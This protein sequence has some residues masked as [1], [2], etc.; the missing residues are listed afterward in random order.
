M[1]VLGA[2]I[3]KM[4]EGLD[5]LSITVFRG[6]NLSK[7]HGNAVSITVF[8]CTPRPMNLQSVDLG[9]AG[10]HIHICGCSLYA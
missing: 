5:F 4:F 7:N 10:E 9:R 8:R 6:L 2:K 3:C 1:A